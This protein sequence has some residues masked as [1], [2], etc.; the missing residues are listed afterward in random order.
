MEA[1]SVRWNREGPGDQVVVPEG[2]EEKVREHR[3]PTRE[4]QGL[5]FKGGPS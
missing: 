1:T 4:R 5:K 2:G 3:M